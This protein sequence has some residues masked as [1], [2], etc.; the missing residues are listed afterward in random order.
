MKSGKLVFVNHRNRSAEGAIVEP[1]AIHHRYAL[2]AELAEDLGGWDIDFVQ[3]S[4]SEGDF[5]LQQIHSDTVFLAQS[6]LSA[7]FE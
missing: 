3:L 7:Q 1:V 4:R 6:K 5:E 2:F